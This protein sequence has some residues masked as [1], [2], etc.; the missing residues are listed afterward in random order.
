MRV[1]V[2]MAIKTISNSKCFL[3]RSIRGS[4]NVAKLVAN[5]PSIISSK[6]NLVFQAD[7]GYTC[8]T[9]RCVS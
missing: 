9:V 7:A 4:V 3:V 8:T 2:Q 5:G 6:A 1:T